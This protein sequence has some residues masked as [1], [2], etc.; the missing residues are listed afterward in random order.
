[1]N[2]IITLGV[3]VS[4]GLNIIFAIKVNSLINEW[5]T[6]KWTA[7]VKYKDRALLIKS[8]VD[9]WKND[10]VWYFDRVNDQPKY[11]GESLLVYDRNGAKIIS[12]C[13]LECLSLMN[14]RIF[15]DWVIVPRKLTNP[16][17]ST[18]TSPLNNY[19]GKNDALE[20]ALPAR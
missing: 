13:D 12:S 19:P 16:Q 14:D 20:P 6:V 18:L 17:S 5:D 9:N 15:V 1:M 10:N 11:M 8:H 7:A 2:K 3:V 4:I